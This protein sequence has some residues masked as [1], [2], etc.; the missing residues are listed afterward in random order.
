LRI[1]SSDVVA[2]LALVVAVVSLTAGN[3]GDHASA[4][5]AGQINGR[6]IV[7]GS[8]TGGKL[9]RDTLTGVQIAEWRLG[10]VPRA[11]NADWLGG[12]PAS[13]YQ[14]KSRNIRCPTEPTDTL[15]VAGACVET[16]ARPPATYTEAVLA[17]KFAAP[18]PPGKH[19][20]THNELRA[21]IG[22]PGIT[23]APGGELTQALA[24]RTPS[25]S[26]ILWYVENSTGSVQM[27]PDENGGAKAFRCVSPPLN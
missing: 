4:G 24:G 27:T 2:T 12:A 6:R 20:P 15:P 16:Q 11:R 7:D 3:G 9:M 21:A 26:L 5:A 25:G 18:R 8:L 17:C 23:L 14:R 1:K 22:E 13:S 19:L 10:K